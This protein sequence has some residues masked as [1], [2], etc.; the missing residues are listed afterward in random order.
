MM[1]MLQV[2][3]AR[4]TVLGLGLLAVL[5]ASGG[6]NETVGPTASTDPNNNPGVTQKNARI[7][8]YGKDGVVKSPVGGRR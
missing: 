2:V 7:Q 5:A 1:H 3:D 4:R 6:C 8:A